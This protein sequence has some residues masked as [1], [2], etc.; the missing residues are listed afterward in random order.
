MIAGLEA[1]SQS[2]CDTV[3]TGL[4]TTHALKGSQG[5]TARRPIEANHEASSEDLSG[6]PLRDT[7]RPHDKDPMRTP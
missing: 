6:Q 5:G 7:L 3:V 2:N 4:V 1:G